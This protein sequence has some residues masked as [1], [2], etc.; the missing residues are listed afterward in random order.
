V[1]TLYI[2][3]TFI[4]LQFEALGAIFKGFVMIPFLNL[5]QGTM[6]QALSSA[7]LKS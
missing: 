7:K 3:V 4:L 5:L 1:F 6:Q 2:Y